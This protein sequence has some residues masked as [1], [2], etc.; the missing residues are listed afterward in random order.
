MTRAA[1]A[2]LAACTP[3]IAQDAPG[4]DDWWRD[5]VFYEVFVRS[6]ADST[7]GPL[8]GDGVGDIPGLIERLDELNDGKPG[9]DDLGVTAL[10]LMP[11]AQSPSYHGYDVADYYNVDDE[12]GTNDDFKRLIDACEHRG[13]RVIIDL[14]LNHCSSENAWFVEARDPDSPKHD[15]FVWRDAVPDWKNNLHMWHPVGDNDTGPY[16]YGF[17]WKGMPDLNFDNPFVGLAAYDISRHWFEDLGAHGFRLDAI[18][19]LIERGETVASTPETIAW[20][21][22]YHAYLKSI[23]PGCFSVGEIWGPTSEVRRYIPDAL[24]SAFEFQLAETIVAGVNSGDPKAL[25]EHI[26][27]LNEAYDNAPFS[28]FLTNHDMDRLM[29]QLGGPSDEAIARNKLAASILLTLPGTPFLYYGE[30]IGMTGVKPDEDIRTPMQWTPDPMKAG[31]TTGDPWRKV[32]N[33]TADINIAAQKNDPDSL[34]RH[35]RDLIELRLGSDAL[36]RGETEVVETDNN[37]LLVFRRALPREEILVLVNL[38]DRP[39]REFGIDLEGLQSGRL[40]R[41]RVLFG[42]ARSRSSRANDEGGL[43]DWQPVT[44]IGPRDVVVVRVIR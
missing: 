4:R 20:L 34:W 8:A 2:L 23:N 6:F 32:N 16:Y 27:H 13:M 5:A 12:Y 9:G 29:S 30:E 1:L 36:R 18:R 10:W 21:T 35:Y 42:N 22:G 33:N 25:A 43:N 40:V 17:F 39:I 28:T 31:F 38:T 14:V 37:D 7:A 41:S 15:W 19:H 26:E 3:A 11:I 44:R 24:D